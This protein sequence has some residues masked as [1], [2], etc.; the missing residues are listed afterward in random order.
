MK[1][2]RNK[3]KDKRERELKQFVTGCLKLTEE[4]RDQIAEKIEEERPKFRE[5]STI[6]PLDGLRRINI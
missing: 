4:K 5:M 2:L 3:K 6:K 1:F